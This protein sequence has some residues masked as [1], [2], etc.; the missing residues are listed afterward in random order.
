MA[1]LSVPVFFNMPC[2]GS[3]GSEVQ[4]FSPRPFKAMGY[5]LGRSPFFVWDG[6][7]GRIDMSS[8]GRK[9]INP[10]GKDKDLFRAQAEV[11]TLQ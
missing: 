9:K 11:E 8:I 10:N 5:G 4:I 2:F 6:I 3:R 7:W 1:F